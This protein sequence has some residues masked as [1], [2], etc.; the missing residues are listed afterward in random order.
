MFNQFHMPAW[1]RT[2]WEEP[3]G[4][5]PEARS[6]DAAADGKWRVGTPAN[7]AVHDALPEANDSGACAEPK[8]RENTKPITAVLA[9]DSE[10]CR[11]LLTRIIGGW[12]GVSLMAAAAD[13]LEALKMVGALKP[14][15]LLLD[16][17]MPGID[18]LF[19]T[20]LIREFHPTTRVILVTGDDSDEV[21]KTCF[22]HGANGFV[23]KR[24]LYCDLRRAITELFPE[25]V[26]DSEPEEGQT[27]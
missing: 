2:F 24:A 7:G 11:E 14:D 12:S 19:A 3:E 26:W 25:S 6:G 23:S 5:R 4:R 20:S 22:D 16:L 21:K 8:S 9:D 18:G 10:F 15:L 17:H 1:Q 27:E 13:G